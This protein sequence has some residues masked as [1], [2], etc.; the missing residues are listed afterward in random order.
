MPAELAYGPL[1]KEIGD[2]IQPLPKELEVYATDE[3]S[4][5]YGLETEVEGIRQA[6]D[7][8]GFDR[9]HLV[10]YSA[11]GA[12][13]LAFTA[14]YPARLKSLVLIEPAWI[15]K[16]TVED[17]EDWTRIGL[18]MSLP[19]D[20]RMRAFQQW[21]MLPGV[22]PPVL[23]IPA[24][25]PPEW[26]KKRP[27]GLVAVIRAFNTYKLDQSRF[28]QFRQPVYYALGSL[29][30]R[31]Y[32]R[33]ARTLAGLFPDFHSEVYQGRSHLDPPHRTEAGRF[34]KTLLE[35]WARAEMI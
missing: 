18:L 6:A 28:V 5:D 31:Y 10:G 1:L 13:S 30:T 9:F 29:S 15:G 34:G 24:G 35:M 25:P 14:R 21:Q 3:P 32:E 2:Q 19:P 17:A 23:P 11:G 33:A 4:P 20:Q 7:R 16:L 27:A 8:A 26:M 22:E 12:S